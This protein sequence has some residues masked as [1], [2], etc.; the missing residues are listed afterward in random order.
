MFEKI[1]LEELHEMFGTHIPMDVIM[2]LEHWGER[3]ENLSALRVYLM[4]RAESWRKDN[5]A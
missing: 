2:A 5:T 4:I 1:T 3:P